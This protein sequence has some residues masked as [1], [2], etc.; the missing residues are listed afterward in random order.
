MGLPAYGIFYV[1]ILRCADNS[2]HV[3][4]TRQD[5]DSRV[6]EH[7]SGPYRSYTFTRRPV[8]LVWSEQFGRLNDAIVCERQLKGWR[9][10]KKEA[11]IRG[12][13]SALPKLA[14]TAKKSPSS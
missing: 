4:L 5:L 7:A 14:K 9:R 2:Y 11:L 13:L 3:G 12:E 6:Y 1:Y 10:A 8:K